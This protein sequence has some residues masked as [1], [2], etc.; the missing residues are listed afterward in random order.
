MD[1][2]KTLWESFTGSGDS[3]KRT[4]KAKTE[5]ERD[6]KMRQDREARQRKENARRILAQKLKRNAEVRPTKA[7]GAHFYAVLA[8]AR[9][10]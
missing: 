9:Y 1:V 3:H 5:K 8:A 4:Q 6:E 2:A 7:T 10:D